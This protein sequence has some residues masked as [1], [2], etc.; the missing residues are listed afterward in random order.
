MRT[1]RIIVIGAGMGGLT[2]AAL[3]IKAG[4]QV[5]VL[6]AHVYP[7]GSAGTFFH[8]GYR[9]DAGATLAGGFSVG[10]PHARIAEI[11]GLEWPVTAVDPAWVVHLGDQVIAQWTDQ[12]QWQEERREK[13]PGSESFWSHQERLAEASW[14]LSSR[15]FPWPP[16]SLKDWAAIIQAVRLDTIPA[17]PYLTHKVRQLF[18]HNASWNLR[19][20]VDAQLLISAQTVSSQ[21][22]ALYG[23]AALDLPRRGVNYVHGGMGSLAWTLVK[24]IRSHGGEV[25]FRQQAVQVIVRQGKAVGVRTQKGLELEG[26]AVVANQTPW[27]LE[28]ILGVHSPEKLRKENLARSPTWGAFTVYAGVESSVIEPLAA[29]HF[30]VIVDPSLPLGEGN[31][32]FASI[33]PLDDAGRAPAGMRALTFSTHTQVEKWWGTGELYEQ[34]KE[35]Y[36]E[37]VLRAAEIAIPGLRRSMRL[38]LPGTPRTFAFYTRRPSGMVGGFAQTSLFSVRGPGTGI[39]NLWLVGD[40]IFPGQSTAGVTLGAMRVAENILA[41]F[42]KKLSEKRFIRSAAN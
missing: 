3:L 15:K 42:S 18:P 24:W 13:F 31:S 29:T 38:C 7:G 22:N 19:A 34:M 4:F 21:A 9:F 20:F 25:I 33:T 28:K 41:R 11:L 16:D 40:S 32:V 8:Q 14:Q 5:T 30:Q 23:S 10:G 17:I 1:P 12:Q 37:R 2:T 6:E 39:D 36:T 27:A 35:E 26:D